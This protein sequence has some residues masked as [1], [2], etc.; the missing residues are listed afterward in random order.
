MIEG[1]FE[2]SNRITAAFGQMLTLDGGEFK[3]LS[4][5][6]QELNTWYCFLLIG[7]P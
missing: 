6:F 2:V 1:G 3:S 7:F 4:F 5:T